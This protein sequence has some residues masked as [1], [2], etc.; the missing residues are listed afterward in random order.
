MPPQED[1]SDTKKNLNALVPA[2]EFLLKNKSKKEFVPFE[3]CK[4]L[5]NLTS[6]IYI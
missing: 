6:L 4:S 2:L 5:C 1:E 3:F